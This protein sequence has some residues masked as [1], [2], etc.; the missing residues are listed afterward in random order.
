LI[1]VPVFGADD[2]VAFGL[3]LYEFPRPENGIRAHIDHVVEAGRRASN[4]L[5]ATASANG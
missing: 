3:T 5:K 1:S 4:I 2:E